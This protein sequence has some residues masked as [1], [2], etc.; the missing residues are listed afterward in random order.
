MPNKAPLDSSISTSAGYKR[1]MASPAA[2][3]PV[4]AKAPSRR[5]SSRRLRPARRGLAAQY[6][7]K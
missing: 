4:A 6:Q 7:K 2:S 1:A 3:T 5:P